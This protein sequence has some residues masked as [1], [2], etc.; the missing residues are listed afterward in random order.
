MTARPGWTDWTA[1]GRPMPPALIEVVSD[2]EDTDTE[3]RSTVTR[4]WCTQCQ[5]QWTRVETQGAV[6][7]ATTAYGS[8][9][10]LNP[11]DDQTVA[12]KAWAADRR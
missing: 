2:E 4:Y 5:L 7:R 8:E 10:S 12:I 1:H 9:F 11:T 6:A 3:S